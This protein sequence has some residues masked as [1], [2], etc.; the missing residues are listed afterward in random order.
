MENTKEILNIFVIVECNVY[1]KL[2][3]LCTCVCKLNK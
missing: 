1:L 3:Q 2:N